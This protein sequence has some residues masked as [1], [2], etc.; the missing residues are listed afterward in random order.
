MTRGVL[1]D[2]A[3]FKG[4]QMLR[5]YLSDHRGR[6]AGRAAAAEAHTAAWRRGH[7]QYRLGAA[8][9]HRGGR[10]MKIEPGP[11]HRGRRVAGETGSHADRHRQRPGQR[12][13]RS[14]S[15]ISAT[16]FIRSR[17]SSTASTC[18]RTSSSTSLRPAS[19][20]GVRAHRS[21]VEDSGWNR[22][23]RCADRDTVKRCIGT[24]G[25]LADWQI[26]NGEPRSSSKRMFAVL[27]AAG[28]LC[29]APSHTGTLRG[30]AGPRLYATWSQPG[31]SLESAQ[32]SALKQINKTNVHQLELQ[33]FHPAPGPVGP[34][35]VQ[36]A[37]GGQRDVCGR[38]RQRG[39][40]ARR[41][42]GKRNMDVSKQRARPP[43]AAST[44]G[45]ARTARIG[46]S[47]SRHA[48]T[49]SSSTPERK[50]HHKLRRE[51]PREPARRA[52]THADRRP[53]ARNPDRPGT[54]SKIFWCWARRRAKGTTRRPVIS[55]RSTS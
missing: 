4:V 35:R 11:H 39:V 29:A 43:T 23:H 51:R 5:G 20:V 17:L 54:C 24:I 46:E 28:L 25:G 34:L 44:T 45:R 50:T 53:A 26:E 2:V 32:Y 37:R 22:I 15:A 47:F 13:T 33:W 31:G 30:Q 3:A 41:G 9:G 12:D 40:C 42:D 16:R 49:F 18:S 7:H 14:G 55:A 21:A 27:L 19:S 6:S 36:S 8:V 48:A 52:G 10:Y 38:E 1:I